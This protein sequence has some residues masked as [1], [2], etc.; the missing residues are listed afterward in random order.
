MKNILITGVS[1]GIGLATAQYFISKNDY[2]VI[3]T[4]RNPDDGD[5]VYAQLGPNF[6]PIL[7]DV[8][9]MDS[10]KEGYNKIKLL[11]PEGLSLLVNNAGIAVSGPLKELELSDFEKQMD[12]NVNGVLR[13]TNTFLPLLGAT[14]DT[15]IPP[16][17]I[18]NISSVSGIFN[19]PLL[20]PYCISK[21][22]LESMSDIYRRELSIYG[23]K[24]IVIEPG[25]TKSE[26]WS[27]AKKDSDKFLH[28][29][30]GRIWKG[31]VRR[32]EK[33][34]SS[35]IDVNILAE[36]IYKVYRKKSPSN[37]YIVTKNKFIN[38]FTFYLVPDRIIDIGLKKALMKGIKR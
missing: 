13:V 8:T 18:I 21:H 35:A 20:G 6:I 9:K 7:L 19:T 2:R 29:D 23:I 33:S 14:L 38:W 10:I 31:M 5:K 1:T 27:K 30:Y 16:G 34:E 15:K 22:A 4:I 26:I 24:V 11:C 32:V 17:T 25:P 36:K 28:T 12:V 3:G 37:R